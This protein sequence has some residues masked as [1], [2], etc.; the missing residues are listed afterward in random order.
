MSKTKVHIKIPEQEYVIEFPIPEWAEDID[1]EE[2]TLFQT[3][4]IKK[5]LLPQ[6]NYEVVTYV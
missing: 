5:Y 2:F 4:E 3:F 1:E 6:I